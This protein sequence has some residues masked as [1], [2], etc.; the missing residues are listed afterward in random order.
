[1]AYLQKE[2]ILT[3]LQ[4]AS[5]PEELNSCLKHDIRNKFHAEPSFDAFKLPY[6]QQFIEW[7]GTIINKKKLEVFTQLMTMP[8]ETVEFTEGVFD[9]L[10]KIFE[11]QDRYIGFEFTNPEL[12]G[13]FERFL[14]EIGDSDFWQ[15]KGFST[16]KVAINSIVILDLPTVQNSQ[17]DRFPRPYYYLLDVQKVKAFEVNLQFKFEYIIFH[18]AHN[19]NLV[20]VFDDGFYRTYSIVKEG[21]PG[22]LVAAEYN[23]VSEVPHDLGYTPARSFWTTPF[24]ECSRLQKRGPQSNSL[25]KFDWLLFL[26]TSMKHVELYA[27]FP[28]D[29]MYEQRCDYR[30]SVGGQCENGKV[31]RV[32]KADVLGQDQRVVFDDCPNCKD[33]QLL[34]AG[35]V[36]TAPAM[37][38]KDDPD[39]LQGMNRIGADKD[40]LE[41]LL[42]RIDKYEATV[43]TNM[44]GYVAEGIREAMNKEQVGSM[45][46]SQINCLSE[47]RDNFQ[48]IHRWVL[49]GLARLR[50]GRG[51]L[52][53]VACNY[54]NKWFIHSVEKLQEQLK[55]SKDN[56][57]PNFELNSQFEQIAQ[58]KY[59][60]NPNMLARVKTLMA[61][62][63]YQNYTV[64]DLGTLNEK[65]G[66]NQ[67]LV[68]LK[69]DFSSYVG[70]FE[71][72]FMNVGAF[73][74]FA[75]FEVKVVFITEKLLQYVA[76]DYAETDAKEAEAKAKEEE[77]KRQ[78]ENP[79]IPPAIPPAE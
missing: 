18:N 19:D 28:V 68:R 75:P 59:K 16:M 76:E 44:I 10:T 50:Y 42:S 71:R 45:L 79:P 65:F 37:A 74:Q 62:E 49:E 22:K 70:R 15:T 77:L 43:S 55:E 33:K 26:Y 8:I 60:N 14:K 21:D 69:I 53:S 7:V 5:K 9:E 29:V 13:D 39:L 34:G 54:G 64:D 24:E 56:G 4:N 2:Q 23:L 58:T 67:N 27:G 48:N 1:M 72:E 47:V 52:I 6:R 66:L 63:P 3:I 61:I 25:G 38:S 20:H 32:V 11:A 35:T 46:E 30:D 12:G 36:L 31:R 73:M 41:Y 57:F 51:A 40:S 17:Q 78:Q